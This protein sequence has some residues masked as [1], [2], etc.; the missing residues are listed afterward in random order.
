MFGYAA[1]DIWFDEAITLSKLIDGSFWQALNPP[2]YFILLSGWMKLFGLSVAAMRALSVTFSVATILVVYMIGKKC[3]NKKIGLLAAAITA[4]SPFQIWYAHEVRAYALL[5][6]ICACA[7]L[8]VV[9]YAKHNSIKHAF[10][11]MIC[12]IAGLYTHPYYVLFFV[13]QLLTL[14]FVYKAHRL[15]VVS[16]GILS[17]ISWLPS[18]HSSLQRFNNCVPGVLDTSLRF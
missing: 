6:F 5:G 9:L 13:S 14:L 11:L 16:I 2:L 7:L 12:S 8:S 4:V 1:R 17:F 10:F 18:V 15:A 3:F